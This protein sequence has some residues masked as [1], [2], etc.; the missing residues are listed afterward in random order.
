M[1]I[2]EM[3]KDYIQ[4]ENTIILAV[5]AA[6]V[7]LGTSESLQFAREFDPEGKRTIGVITKLDLMD[8]GTN[9]LNIFEGKLLPL[10][11]GY[12]GV[13]NRGQKDIENRVSI[14]TCLAQ[15]LAWLSQSPYKH[16]MHRMG[17][18]YLAKVLNEQLGKHIKEKLPGIRTT[19][20]KRITLLNATLEDMGYSSADDQDKSKLLYA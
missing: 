13:V 8:E 19:I 15:E 7:D 9:A 17:S 18:T 14:E 3:I 5:S 2:K 20:Q 1:Q 12:I 10:K 16:I 11:L 4:E 6:N